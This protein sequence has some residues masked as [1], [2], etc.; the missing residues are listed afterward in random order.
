M[1]GVDTSVM[2]V[3]GLIVLAIGSVL[4]VVPAASTGD[5]SEWEALYRPLHLPEIGAGGTPVRC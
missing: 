5:A 4:C 2:R 3:V 1:H